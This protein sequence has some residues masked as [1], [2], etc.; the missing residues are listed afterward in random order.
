MSFGQNWFQHAPQ[1]DTFGGR[2]TVFK[3]FHQLI[4]IAKYSLKIVILLL[5]I[6]WGIRRGGGGHKNRTEQ[7]T[8]FFTVAINCTLR[9]SL[10]L[11]E[12]N[13]SCWSNSHNSRMEESQ[14]AKPDFINIVYFFFLESGLNWKFCIFVLP[15]SRSLALTAIMCR[16][17]SVC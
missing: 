16:V 17:Q 13:C 9:V 6:R 14:S 1:T 15:F 11:C 7:N 8:F 2:Q 12:C 5:K 4:S 3:S 10:T